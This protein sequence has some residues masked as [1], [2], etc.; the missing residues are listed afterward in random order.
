VSFT[1]FIYLKKILD[2]IV[3]PKEKALKLNAHSQVIIALYVLVV[4]YA[5]VY[6]FPYMFCHG[7]Q[8]VGMSL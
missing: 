1:I 3:F 8:N 2:Y 5:L 4:T 7:L 6:M